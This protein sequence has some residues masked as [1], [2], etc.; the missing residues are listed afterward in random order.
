M[1]ASPILP[2]T[3]QPTEG[4]DPNF[5]QLTQTRKAQFLTTG[6]APPSPFYVELND[7]LR[8]VVW[9]SLANV[10]VLLMGRFM[11]TDG[12]IVPFATSF[13][14][15]SDR[16]ANTFFLPMGEGYFL[17]IVAQSSIPT[18][19]P[20]RGQTF[21]IIDI[22]RGGQ[23]NALRTAVLASD[24]LV[25]GVAISWPQSPIRQSVEGPGFIQ[26][27][28]IANPAAGANWIATVPTN[29][30]WRIRAATF[31]LV[32]SAAVATRIVELDALD[33]AGNILNV[34]PPFSSQAAS[35]N[36]RYNVS[37]VTANPAPDNTQVNIPIYADLQLMAAWKFQSAVQAIQA[38]DQ[39]SSIFLT[40]EE[41][42]ETH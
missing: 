31:V 14:P 23:I 8:L 39:L 32:T 24:Y 34:F 4:P 19:G 18:P 7:V 11:L 20:I 41:W 16:V 9:N 36:F 29:A 38:A 1:G 26:S 28:Q 6:I 17:D 40:I 22:L 3:G 13:I 15:T 33:N 2:Q 42:I 12:T 25:D 27:L 5:Q 35:L 21:A 30:R 10:K 37:N